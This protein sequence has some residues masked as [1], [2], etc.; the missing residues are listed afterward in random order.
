[1]F[2]TEPKIF[3]VFPVKKTPPGAIFKK[4]GNLTATVNLFLRFFMD[5]I[6]ISDLRL[7]V[8]VGT[9]AAERTRRQEISIDLELELDLAAAG[10]SDDLRDTVD[11]AEIERRVI[12]LAENS[13][14]RLLEALADAIG[15]LALSYDRIERCRVRIVKPRA[16]RIARGVAIEMNFAKER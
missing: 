7:P 13:S 16:L 15:R 5:K 6:I 11:Y 3:S 1:M 14:F 4:K 10:R 2:S 8:I 12:E 9:L